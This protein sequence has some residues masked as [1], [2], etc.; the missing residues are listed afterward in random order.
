MKGYD[1][2]GNRI[3]STTA[4]VTREWTANGLNQFTAETGGAAFTYDL[5]GN[6]LSDGN[7]DYA[8]DAEN[9]LVAVNY[10]GKR[11]EWSYDAFNR[12]VQQRDQD[13]T[14]GLRT[15]DLIWD[16][17]S[18]IESRNQ[19]TGEVRRYYSNGE[20]RE[21]PGNAVLRLSYTT[22]HL[23]SIRELVD[24]TGAIRARYDYDPYGNRTKQPG[25]DL[26]ADF[27]YTG[28]YTHE[29]SGLILA[30]YRGYDPAT[31]RWLSRDPIEEEGG[32]N[33][34]GYVE[35]RPVSFFDSLGFEP[36]VNLLDKV[37][38]KELSEFA[39]KH[40]KPVENGA[41]TLIAHSTN[42]SYYKDGRP[43]PTQDVADLVKK[44]PEY[45]PGMPIISISC[46]GMAGGAKSPAAQLSQLLGGTEVSGP[47]KK[48]WPNPKGKT[49][50][51]KLPLGDGR[52]VNGK[53]Y[54]TNSDGVW[55][56]VKMPPQK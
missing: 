38:D 43:I 30:P 25:G 26:D 34:Y 14:N 11:V 40:I 28:H 50:R 23:G 22:D 4:G 21:I 9:R 31:G 16:G 20:E 12:R 1:D 36:A 35:N 53:W 13:E 6:L 39:A 46:D 19:A 48:V 47:T 3:A 29:A 55:S 51:E 33:L 7:R 17:L 56:S 32:V 24:G 41:L 42:D 27:G 2:A 18:L 44:C 45:K 10:A 5:D 49:M 52:Y 37:K 54:K 8:W 15:R